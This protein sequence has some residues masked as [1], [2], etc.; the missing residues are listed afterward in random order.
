[1]NT[2]C[3]HAKRSRNCIHITATND[4]YPPKAYRTIGITYDQSKTRALNALLTQIINCQKATSNKAFDPPTPGVRPYYIWEK[5]TISTDKRYQPGSIHQKV[6]LTNER[7]KS[8]R[9]VAMV[10]AKSKADVPVQLKKLYQYQP[11]PL[12]S[13]EAQ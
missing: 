6:T 8:Y 2:Y 12:Q 13:K 9:L 4:T 1:M 11:L 3:L 7:P 5:F 10:K